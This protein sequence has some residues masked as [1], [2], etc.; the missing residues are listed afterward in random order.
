MMRAIH[1]TTRNLFSVRAAAVAG[2]LQDPAL[3]RG[4][5][6]HGAGGEMALLLDTDVPLVDTPAQSH[7]TEVRV[8]EGVIEIGGEQPFD[9]VKRVRV[10]SA[11]DCALS[12]FRTGVPPRTWWARD[13][14]FV[15]NDPDRLAHVVEMLLYRGNTSLTCAPFKEKKGYA[16]R[17]ANASVYVINYCR[18]EGLGEVFYRCDPESG[19]RPWYVSWGCEFPLL[20]HLGLLGRDHESYTLLRPDSPAQ[21]IPAEAFH[22]VS[23]LVEA[24]VSAQ[25]IA[26][27]TDTAGKLRIPVNI[28]IEKADPI[29]AR[30]LPAPQ[31]WLIPENV[32][33]LFAQD[34]HCPESALA[35]FDALAFAAGERRYI[36][37]WA[38]RGDT[39][40]RIG[41]L[42]SLSHPETLG[43]YRCREA[44]R[45]LF[46]PAGRILRPLLQPRTLSSVFSLNENRFT[47]LIPGAS[48]HSVIALDSNDFRPVRKALVDYVFAAHREEI[49]RLYAQPLYDFGEPVVHE[50]PRKKARRTKKSH[51]AGKGSAATKRKRT[52]LDPRSAAESPPTPPPEETGNAEP[53]TAAAQEGHAARREQEDPR[54]SERPKTTEEQ[55]IERA[56]EYIERYDHLTSQ[57]WRRFMGLASITAR[58]KSDSFAAL[59][60]VLLPSVPADWM[61]PVICEGLQR[62]TDWFYSRPADRLMSDILRANRDADTPE[63]A[64]FGL[65]GYC[66]RF[67]RLRTTVDDTEHR[68]ALTRLKDE[69][70][71]DGNATYIWLYSRILHALTGD[72][73]ALEEGRIAVQNLLA[74][75]TVDLCLPMTVRRVAGEQLLQE[76]AHVV[77]SFREAVALTNQHGAWWDELLFLNC[78]LSTSLALAETRLDELLGR[79]QRETGDLYPRPQAYALEFL[80]FVLEVQ[81]CGARHPHHHRLVSH[82]PAN[83]HNPVI[84]AITAVCDLHENF[85]LPVEDEL[86]AAD[87]LH[88]HLLRVDMPARSRSSWTFL[89]TIGRIE[90]MARDEGFG[91]LEAL[92]R[93]RVGRWREPFE[94]ESAAALALDLLSRTAGDQRPAGLWQS[95]F[96]RI[97]AA[98]WSI[99]EKQDAFCFAL[100]RMQ[101]LDASQV[102][103]FRDALLRC[104]D[105]SGILECPDETPLTPGQVKVMYALSSALTACLE[106]KPSKLA[107]VRY[108]ER[109]AIRRIIGEAFRESTV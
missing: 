95:A 85:C 14:L 38:G 7:C 48:R 91:S 27:D 11:A 76:Y 64:L 70:L 34:C 66:A 58:Y 83:E 9:I 31:L 63:E 81:Q 60:H 108:Y 69:I 40:N 37:L 41:A 35:Q 20:R 50:Q 30:S 103:E 90:R 54:Q 57:D 49:H 17:A 105:Q 55:L 109:A 33:E 102:E 104:L 13:V 18:G 22:G 72:T 53:G 62:D 8:G 39:G 1:G 87:A 78:I 74:G 61:L 77:E 101:S 67:F 5:L 79:I 106:Q 51:A 71:A 29:T 46:V 96:Q 21:E 15:F 43:L 52:S 75:G 19:D 47:V 97:S 99:E 16:L 56:T 2:H 24:H 88:R 45:P 44:E 84:P 92:L 89:Y 42:A 36:A 28:G 94:P 65:C 98:Q 80:K 59:A 12:C 93:E 3:L 32:I 23:S 4:E 6:C 26:A 10:E 107:D 25:R 82:L 68:D 100:F 73:Q 86:H